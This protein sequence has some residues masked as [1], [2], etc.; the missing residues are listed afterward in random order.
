M[1]YYFLRE[2]E[3]LFPVFFPHHIETFSTIYLSKHFIQLQ[4][5]NLFNQKK[6]TNLFNHF[7]FQEQTQRLSVPM[8]ML[9]FFLLHLVSSL[10]PPKPYFPNSIQF[11]SFILLTQINTWVNTNLKY[12][13]TNKPKCWHQPVNKKLT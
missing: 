4:V 7:S 1:C 3:N 10:H 13:N 2:Y 6:V 8:M 12:L 11:S 5:T 9:N